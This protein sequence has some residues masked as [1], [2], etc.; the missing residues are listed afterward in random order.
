MNLPILP[1]LLSLF[2][3]FQLLRRR[4]MRFLRYS[5]QEQKISTIWVNSLIE[6]SSLNTF[7]NHAL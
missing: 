4:T 2:E 6:T 5:N 7:A 1:A 3:S